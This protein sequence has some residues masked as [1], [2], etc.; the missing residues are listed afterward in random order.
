MCHLL[1]L[2]PVIGLP[3]FW[4]V[5]L[6][7]ALPLYL[8]IA[9]ISIISYWIMVSSMRKPVQTGVETLI[10]AEAQVV[11]PLSPGHRAQYLVRS[12]GELW[13]ARCAQALQCGES[14]TVAAVDG[15]CLQVQRRDHNALP[16]KAGVET[17]PGGGRAREGDCH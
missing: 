5:P 4:L 12:R 13:T 8:V 1:L 2:L 16:E 14:V 15:I 11:S 7:L 10:G 6:S 17:R 3:I 9:V